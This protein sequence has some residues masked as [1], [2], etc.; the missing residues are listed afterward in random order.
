MGMVLGGWH[1]GS[2]GMHL[3]GGWQGI[4]ALLVSGG[5]VHGRWV[6]QQWESITTGS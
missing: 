2:E 1:S 4:R 3:R 6:G 5:H